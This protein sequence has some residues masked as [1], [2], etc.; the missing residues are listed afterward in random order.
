M[1]VANALQP[2]VL[3]P[4]SWSRE[5]FDAVNLLVGRLGGTVILPVAERLPE[6]E[7][8]EFNTQLARYGIK[9][10]HKARWDLS[11]GAQGRER[12]VFTQVG[13]E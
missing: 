5:H 10:R 13:A 8:A 7:L 11:E 1:V 4:S 12:I 2:L 3:V 9:A 6:S